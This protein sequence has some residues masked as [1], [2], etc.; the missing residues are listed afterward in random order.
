M[1]DT[2]IELD[3]LAP[4]MPR[5]AWHRMVRTGQI[6]KA[7]GFVAAVV[8]LLMGQVTRL[9]WL[10]LGVMYVLTMGAITAGMHR[11]FAHRS[12]EATTWLRTLLAVFATMAAQGSVLVWVANH[13]EHHQFSDQTADPHSPTG[14]FWHAHTG[15]IL[16]FYPATLA[17]YVPDLMAD[18]T[19]LWLHRRLVLVVQAGALGPAF[20]GLICTGTWQGALGGWIWGG[21][22][23]MFLVEQSTCTVNSICHMWGSRPFAT[24]DLSANVAPLALFTLGES[25]HNNH[26]AF[27]SSARHGL[28]W[29]QADPTYWAIRTW[30]ALGLVSR[31]VVPDMATQAKRRTS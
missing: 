19:L 17:R 22:A 29:W 7:L 16:G 1:L 15:W 4:P 12:Y 24:R 20:I 2:T 11:L 3:S 10:L 31:V 8:M 26:H 18:R 28:R 21:W 30:Q 25:W 5:V 14:G 23:R 9:D 27:P 6:L 13:R